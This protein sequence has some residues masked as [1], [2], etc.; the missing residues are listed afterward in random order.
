MDGNNHV[1]R[2]RCKN[3]MNL[4]D[5]HEMREKKRER[6]KKYDERLASQNAQH[7]YVHHESRH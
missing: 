7:Y 4:I 5:I 1:I 2:V 6:K 3:Y